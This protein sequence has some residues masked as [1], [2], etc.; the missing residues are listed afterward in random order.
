MIACF[1]RYMDSIVVALLLS[2]ESP[3][4]AYLHSKVH[5]DRA[6]GGVMGFLG[7]K[8]LAAAQPAA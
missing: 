6:A 5:I 2:A 4:A 3:R 8:L 7:L 1:L